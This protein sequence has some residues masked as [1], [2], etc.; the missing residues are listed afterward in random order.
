MDAAERV[1]SQRG[2]NNAT[3]DQIA[4]QAELS[5][6]TLYL[7]FKNK[8]ELYLAIATRALTDLT[9]IWQQA[10]DS[11]AYAS[12][13]ELYKTLV[14]SLLEYALEHRDRFRVA[15]GWS[16]SEYILAD[17]C[18]GFAEYQQM[19]AASARCG[20]D[21]LELGKS[22]GSV[23]PDL[24]TQST[25]FHVWGGTGGMLMMIYGARE[26]NR[27]L[28]FPI[29]M[30][31]ALV[32]HVTALLASIQRRPDDTAFPERLK[33]ILESGRHDG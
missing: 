30:N 28:P 21:A 20:Y 19:I 26:T 17:D 9:R 29:D 24:D 25:S 31:K 16:A 27:R 15:L 23:R 6:G 12:G 1:F 18:P 14:E 10:A 33:A 13:F 32:D 7:Y 5:K 22:D 11:G 8:D 4:H 2:V 3:M